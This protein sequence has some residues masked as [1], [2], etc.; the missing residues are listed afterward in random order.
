MYF[1]LEYFQFMMGLLGHKPIVNGRRSLWVC[2][3]VCALCVYLVNY[4]HTYIVFSEIKLE[5][6]MGTV[7]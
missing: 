4:T 2:I 1:N 7:F 6:W 3:Y 5:N